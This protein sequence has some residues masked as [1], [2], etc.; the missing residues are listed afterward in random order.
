MAAGDD[1]TVFGGAGYLV[2]VLHNE[3]LGQLVP[4]FHHLVRVGN[5][6]AG[7]VVGEFPGSEGEERPTGICCV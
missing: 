6:L 1:F 3:E 7:E 2:V 4:A 5:G